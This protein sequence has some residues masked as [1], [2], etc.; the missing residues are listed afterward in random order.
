MISDSCKKLLLL[1]LCTTL[2]YLLPVTVFAQSVEAIDPSTTTSQPISPDKE[3]CPSGGEVCSTSSVNTGPVSKIQDN[4]P[5]PWCVQQLYR[6]SGYYSP[7]PNQD[8]YTR[9]TYEQEIRLNGRGTNGASWMP[10]FNGMVAAPKSYAF[11]TII[12]LPWLGIGQ[13]QDRWW[14]IVAS[15]WYDRIDV[16]LGEWDEGIHRAKS[17]GL[18]WVVGRY[19]PWSVTQD[20]WFDYSKIPQYTDFVSVAFWSIDQN[21]GRGGAL[22]TKLQSYLRSLGYLTNDTLP[23]IYDQQMRELVC[24]FQIDQL[25]LNGNEDYCG[26]FGPQTRSTLKKMLIKKWIL[27]DGSIYNLSNSKTISSLF[28]QGNV[29]PAWNYETEPVKPTSTA[30]VKPS[31]SQTTINLQATKTTFTKTIELWEESDSV[32]VLQKILAREWLFDRKVTGYFWPITQAALAQFQLKYKLIDSLKHPAAGWTGPA[33]R[34]L[35]TKKQNLL[36]FKSTNT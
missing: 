5:Y 17:V 18:R 12:V 29:R 13:V 36:R 26:L 9:D 34:A 6:I 10:V 16:W 20:I 8:V 7:K 28:T 30:V 33:T 21:I 14:A 23:W 24:R 27:S 32:V 2:Y 19:C 1:L 31:S 25:G 22:V 35:L 15:D 4:A 11:G 3:R